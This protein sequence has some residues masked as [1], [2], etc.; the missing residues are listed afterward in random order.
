LKRFEWFFD[1]GFGNS[2]NFAFEKELLVIEFVDM[3]QIGGSIE[4]GEYD[5]EGG[6]TVVCMPELEVLFGLGCLSNCKPT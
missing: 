5:F 2:L 3:H 1:S 6:F 4:L